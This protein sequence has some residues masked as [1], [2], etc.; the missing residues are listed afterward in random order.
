MSSTIAGWRRPWLVL[1]GARVNR[2]RP[3]LDGLR[4]QADPEAFVWQILPHAA[5]TFSACISLL[6]PRIARAAA[7]GNLY[8]RILDTYEDQHPDPASREAA[9]RAF[10]TRLD[11]TPPTPAPPIPNAFQQ[12]ARDATHLL[13]VE[14]CDMVDRVFLTLDEGQQQAVRS[15][16]TAMAEG[17]CWSS[18]VFVEQDGVLADEAQLLRYCR[19]VIGHPVVFVMHLLRG[20][21]LPAELTEHAMVVGEMVQLANITRDIEKDLQRGVAYHPDLRSQLNGN[22]QDPALIRRARLEFLRLALARVPAYLRIVEA[23]DFDRI[24]P[25]RASALLM[26]LF[27]DRHYRGCARRLGL[28]SWS[29]ADSWPALL[30]QTLPA[31]VSP[32]Y[33][34]R[35]LT[36]VQENFLGALRESE[37]H[38]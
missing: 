1:N 15:V 13:L 17:M 5:R 21:H 37:A 11:T 28:P 6:P 38:A 36:R 16:V 14:R 33:T 9:L 4:Q 18:R 10:A 8:C 35:M 30:R 34:R 19:N 26:L 7:V 3:D 12:D 27:T 31:V 25:T 20:D 22:P 23:I 2:D 32:H 29:G 24:S